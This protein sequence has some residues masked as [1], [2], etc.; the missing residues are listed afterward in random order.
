[1]TDRQIKN[2]SLIR[3]MIAGALFSSALFSAAAWSQSSFASTY[4][5]AGTSG[6]TCGSTY[7]IS[8]VEPSTAGTHPVFAYMVGTNETYNNASAMAAVNSM[9]SKGYVAATIEYASGAFGSCA[10]ISGKAS[11]AFNPNSAA[12]A[13]SQLC[14][15]A[16]ADCSKGIVVAGFSQ[17]SIMAILAKNYDSRVQAA[18]GMGANVQYSTYDL[19]SCVAN[20]NRTL[21]SDRL[22][23]VNGERDNFGGSTVSAVRGQLQELTGLNCGTSAYSCFNANNSGWIMAKN[24]QVADGSADHCYMRATGGC[25]GSQSTLD[26]GWKAGTVNWELESNLNWLNSFTSK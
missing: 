21:P 14:S 17:G 26:T 10:V 9:A 19:R 13:V 4:S 1:M 16:K 22:R 23:A 8:G 20:G 15:R 24:S 25:F 3:M 5:G 7:N 12:S 11:C 18:Y 2:S 6:G